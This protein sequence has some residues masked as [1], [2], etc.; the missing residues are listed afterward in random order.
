[1][2]GPALDLAPVLLLGA[3]GQVGGFV[4]PKLLEA[5]APVIAVSR[6]VPG[7][8]RDGLTWLQQD[9]QRE[10]ARVQAQVMLS[11]GPLSLALKQAERIG[12]LRRVVALSSASVLFKSRSPD[13]AERRIVESLAGTEK[14]LENLCARRDIALTL[15]RP[16]LIYGDTQQSGLASIARWV[17]RHRWVPVAGRGQRQP[18]HA[19]DLAALMTRLAGAGDESAGIYELGGGE[20][21]SY[22]NFVRRI[23]SAHG[24]DARIVR[25]PAPL[26]ISLVR[27]A[28]A[29]GR[30]ESVTPAMVG[31]QRMDLVVDDTP[32]RERLGWDPRP[33]RP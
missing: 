14:A 2:A 23:A 10:P 8:A 31:R 5:G 25:V 4:V 12:G 17:A 30:L 24:R 22:P 18:V 13:P 15:L 33:F 28:R 26:L 32:A 1:M 19:G 21:L 6:R 16:T 20:T 27:A 29:L 3:T 9:L 7:F 11:A